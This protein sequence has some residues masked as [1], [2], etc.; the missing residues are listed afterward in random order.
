[1]IARIKHPLHER[2]TALVT[3]D[4]HFSDNPR[5]AYRFH[6]LEEELP[7]LV[8]EHSVQQL[9]ILGDITESKDGHKASLV[10]RMVDGIAALAQNVDVYILKGNHD[11]TAQD[12][13]FYRFLDHIPRVR[14]I[15]EPEVIR[16]EGLGRCLFLPHT[17]DYGDWVDWLMTPNG[18]YDWYFCHQT[19][20]GADL[21]HGH[22]VNGGQ[23]PR[24]TFGHN[25]HVISGD[26]HVPQ[27]IGPVTYVGSPYA[28]DFGD[29]TD[30][31]ILLL[32]GETM[33]PVPVTGPQKQLVK[34][35][36]ATPLDGL[37]GAPAAAVLAGDVVRVTID[38]PAGCEM[39]RAAIRA[40]V[41]A[42]AE[43][44]GVY[45]D[46]VKITSAAVSREKK[47]IHDRPQ[48]DDDQ[49]VRDYARK[50]KKGKATVEAGLKIMEKTV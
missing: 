10:N 22:L 43:E 17:N 50:M 25:A 8:A 6:F 11:Y 3:A 13:P 29:T 7:R 2:A 4:L 1:M 46:S 14:W 21:G 16:L 23:D 30:T 42:W 36:G 44:A 31:Q 49:L 39:S 35:V 20:G 27:K 38:L 48:R 15:N 32:E 12:V 45:L 28:V 9:L 47:A 37:D 34:L 26:V 33:L 41:R 24:A 19:F 5:D 40:E 18:D